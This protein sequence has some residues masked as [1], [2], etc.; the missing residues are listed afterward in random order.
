LGIYAGTVD[1]TKEWLDRGARY[2]TTSLE[3][4]LRDG[5]GAHLRAV[6]G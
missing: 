2:F 3:P 6:R 5:M 4:F 1:M